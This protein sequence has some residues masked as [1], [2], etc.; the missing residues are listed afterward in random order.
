ML[1]ADVG[2]AV[3]VAV[4]GAVG[5]SVGGTVEDSVGGG[6]GVPVPNDGVW[7]RGRVSSDAHGR[8]VRAG[9]GVTCSVGVVVLTTGAAVDPVSVTHPASSTLRL[10]VRTHSA[11]P[12]FRR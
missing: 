7:H 11:V 10:T 12:Q 2:D 1:G 6:V 8:G 5:G 3:G 4:G 9:L